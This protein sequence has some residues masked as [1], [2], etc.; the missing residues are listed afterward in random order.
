MADTRNNTIRRVDLAEKQVQTVAGTRTR[1]L[2]VENG[3]PAGSTGLNSPWDVLWRDG[4]VYIAMAGQHQIWVLDPTERHL[5]AFAGNRKA[6]LRDGP[7]LDAG[8]N[9]PSSLATDSVR[10]FV[11]DS[12]GDAIRVMGFD[13]GSSVSTL[14]GPPPQRPDGVRER[15]SA[16]EHPLGVAWLGDRL[17]VADT[18]N[19][20]L[21]VLDPRTGRVRTLVDADAGLNEPAGV[22]AAGGRIYVADTNNHR[23]VSVDPENGVLT[24]VDVRE[25]ESA[26]FRGRARP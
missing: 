24:P 3:G 20:R 22:S 16:L 10:L 18:Y 25:G 6:E 19:N 12:E 26:D 21:R 14:I 13:P 17:V 4:R 9:Q 2:Q 1:V 11:A 15:A 5:Q 23:I 8:L 7:L